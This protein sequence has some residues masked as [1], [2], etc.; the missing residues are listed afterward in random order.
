MWVDQLIKVLEKNLL[1]QDQKKKLLVVEVVVGD[2]VV[3]SRRTELVSH[4]LLLLQL[5]NYQPHRLKNWYLT[6]AKGRVAKILLELKLCPRCCCLP[7]D[8]FP[9]NQVVEEEKDWR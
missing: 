2:V 9:L 3:L 8:P 1:V 4:P 5:L 6:W 7:M